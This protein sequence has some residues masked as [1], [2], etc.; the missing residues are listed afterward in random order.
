MDIS[1]SVSALVGLAGVILGAWLTGRNQRIERRLSF[2][3]K[4]LKYF[5]SPMLGLRNEIKMRSQLRERIQQT[6]DE[7]WKNLCKEARRISEERLKRLSE[8]RFPEFANLVNYDNRKLQ[9]ELLPAYRQ[10]AK[11]FCENFWLADADTRDYY[12]HL[13]EF[14]EIWDRVLDKS[15]PGEVLDKL[16]HSEEKL[17]PFYRHLQERHDEL[18]GKIKEA[19]A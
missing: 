16:K 15:I 11:L 10:M 4:Q 2:I 8:E 5:Y 19:K 7:V 6:A 3:E 17:M 1:I 14:I 13:I 9:D 12:P 18:R